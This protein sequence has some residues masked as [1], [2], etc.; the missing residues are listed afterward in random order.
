VGMESKKA[1]G[2][3]D[4]PAGTGS[5]TVHRANLNGRGE[6]TATTS[7]DWLIGSRLIKPLSEY[8]R[9]AMR[10]ALEEAIN[11]STSAAD[12]GGPKKAEAGRVELQDF[13]AHPQVIMPPSTSSASKVTA[14]LVVI[15][16]K[17]L[18]GRTKDKDIGYIAEHL[19]AL[20]DLKE[21][22]VVG[23]EAAAI[24]HALNSLRHR[25]TYLFTG[26]IGPTHGDI[27]ADCVAK[28]F[29]VPVDRHPRAL[30]ILHE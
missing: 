7:R 6:S 12:V 10:T 30:A 23:D 16:S 17:T 19:T 20:L 5:G 24:V 22:R 28:A 25:C 29:G 8:D 1:R 4:P 13:C 21:V 9:A 2:A 3:L 11:N 18:S 15:S 14:A 26:G 27:A